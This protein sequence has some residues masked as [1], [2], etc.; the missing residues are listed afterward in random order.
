MKK[1]FI[2]TLLSVVLCNSVVQANVTAGINSQLQ[3]NIYNGYAGI[4]KEVKEIREGAIK[5]YNDQLELEK[6]LKDRRRQLKKEASKNKKTLYTNTVVNVR[7]KPSTESKILKTLNWNTAV[8]GYEFDGWFYLNNGGCIRIDLLSNNQVSFRDMPA[9]WNSGYKSWMSYN[10]IT[11]TNSK[12][13]LIQH[14]Y[15]YDGNYGI[16]QV[17]G[18]YCVALGSY[19]GVSIGQYFDLILENG[20]AIPCIAGDAKANRDTD[21]INATTSHNGCMSEFIVSYYAL[22]KRARQSGNISSV[23]SDWNSPINAVRIYDKNVL[24]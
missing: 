16:R 10:T 21:G 18:R 8:K 9:P 11:D 1:I 13:Y 7:K 17:N 3:P 5:E 12:Q 19:F 24:E 20:T 14:S 4:V 6:E 22:D 23:S 2:I 15:A